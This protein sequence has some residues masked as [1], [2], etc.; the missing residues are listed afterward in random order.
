MQEQEI[1]QVKTA[2]RGNSW[3][4]LDVLGVCGVM[5]CSKMQEQEFWQ[6]ITSRRCDSSGDVHVLVVYGVMGCSKYAGA[7][8]L[9][10]ENLK[11]G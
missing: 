4:D 5:G 1:W 2:R 8:D 9:T 7:R 3:G 10:S 11:K 6:E